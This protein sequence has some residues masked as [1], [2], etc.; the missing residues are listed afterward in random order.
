MMRIERPV[1]AD[2]GLLTFEPFAQDEEM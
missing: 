1:G 2:M